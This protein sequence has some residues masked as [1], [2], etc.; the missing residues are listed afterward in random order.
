MCNVTLQNVKIF[1]LFWKLG[2]IIVIKPKTT[3]HEISVIWH[4]SKVGLT[5]NEKRRLHNMLNIPGLVFF[6]S[7][8][9][10]CV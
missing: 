1:I 7:K 3:S 10:D 9:L 6:M 2:L 8:I 5:F 4:T